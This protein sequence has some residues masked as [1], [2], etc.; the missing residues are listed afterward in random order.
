MMITD[1]YIILETGK[2]DTYREV[3]VEL[4]PLLL[5]VHPV[6]PPGLDAADEAEELLLAAALG[7]DVAAADEVVEG[8]H[9]GELVDGVAAAGARGSGWSGPAGGPRGRRGR[10]AGHLTRFR[11]IIGAKLGR[12]GTLSRFDFT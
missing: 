12:G 10:E 9:Q 2:A 11:W 5:G 8:R 1:K 6:L 4:G 3:A 7:E